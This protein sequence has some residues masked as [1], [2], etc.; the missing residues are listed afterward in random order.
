MKPTL[1]ALARFAFIFAALIASRPLANATPPPG[2]TQVWSDEFTG[3]TLDT[4]YWNILTGVYNN[5]TR[6]PNAISVASGLLTITTYTVNNVHYTAFISTR[7]RYQPLYGYI[8]ASISNAGISGVNQA[9]WLHSPTI[10]NPIG[11][12]WNAGIEMDISEYRIH[13]NNNTDISDKNTSAIHWDGYAA[14]HKSLTSG[15]RATGLATGF[16]T[17]ALEWTP[18]YTKFYIDGAYQWTVNDS[19][20]SPVSQ[21][22]EYIFFTAAVTNGGWPG[23]IPAGGYGSLATSTTKMVVDYVRV[24]QLAPV[25][26]PAPTDLMT[27]SGNAQVAL[28]W[29]LPEDATTHTIK[30]SLSSGGPYSVV[31]SA[32]KG[33]RYTDTSVS[34]GTTYYYVVSASNSSGE[35]ANSSEVSASPSA[36]LSEFIVDNADSSGVTITGTWA[37]ST[38]TTGYYGTNYLH[39]GATGAT[40]GKSVRFAP[41]LPTSTRYDVYLNWTSELARGRNVPIDVNHTG[42][43]TE[44]FIDQQFNGGTWYQLGTFGFNAGTGGNVTVRNDGASNY[45]VADAVKFVQV[46]GSV[47]PPAAPAGVSAIAGN[48]RIILNWNASSGATS[49]RVKR[50][51]TSGGPYSLVASPTTTS[52]TNTGLVNGTAYYYVITAV[53]AAG[54]SGNSAQVTAT[55]QAITIVKDNS[56]G[57]GV[58]LTGAWSASTTTPGY[59]GSNYLHDGN[60]QGGKSVRFNPTITT[61]GYYEVYA[62]WPAASNRATNASFDVNHATGTSTSTKNQQ[63][64]NNTWV[65][66]GT[67]LFN[68]GTSGNVTLRDDAANG[69]VMADAVEFVLK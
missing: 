29:T 17:Y 32:V 31:A 50:A 52:Y 18:L 58:T 56:E 46:G 64:N 26:P 16:H 65:L 10:G 14:D 48:A 33:N 23:T 43:T 62:R 68:S 39:D 59:Y 53:N 4:N 9:F 13:D 27:G 34:N 2:Y 36:T 60:A 69:Y 8:E 28:K 49:Y 45:V 21:R 37:T 1:R 57:T 22:S 3:T 15:L 51:T 24:Y 40:G 7:D 12:P 42:G 11:D 55:P 44:I 20:T 25:V 63:Q 5:G 35:G 66:L 38:S 54:E 6:T 41:N 61:A 19:S 30:R 67:Y 47:S